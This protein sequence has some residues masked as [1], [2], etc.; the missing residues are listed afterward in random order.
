MKFSSTITKGL[1][2]LLSSAT[3]FSATPMQGSEPKQKH[4]IGGAIEGAIV[5]GILGNI[6][7]DKKD[8]KKAAT[9][10][11]ALG[12]IGTA[13][14]NRKEKESAFREELLKLER[15]RLALKRELS[16]QAQKPVTTVQLQ[17]A[18]ITMEIKR[19]LVI[20]GYLEGP[21]TKINQDMLYTA[22]KTYQ[23]VSRI[24]VD[25]FPTLGLLSHLRSHGG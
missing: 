19:S 24:H 20:L 15:E 5:G 22:I 16:K 21:T 18:D 7:G 8:G 12:A 10:G 11:A 25:G 17:N 23:R 1:L 2:V 9:I 3:L 14:R 4:V 13:E 6:F